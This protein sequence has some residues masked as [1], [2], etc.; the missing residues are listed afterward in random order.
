MI[1]Y[2]PISRRMFLVG[3][4]YV[5]SIPL[6]T[7]L[8]PRELQATETAPPLRFIGMA[9]PYSPSEKMFYGQLAHEVSGTTQV[10][11][12][13]LVNSVKYKSLS[14]ISGDISYILQP[15]TNLK[16]KISIV[17]GLDMVS[18]P[19]GAHPANFAM[20]AAGGAD[21]GK[22]ESNGY[23]PSVDQMIAGS[24]K[25]YPSTWSSLRRHLNLSPAY[26]SAST[27]N[28][29]M[30]LNPSWQPG[31]D[32][33][34]RVKHANKIT[35]TQSLMQRFIGSFDDGGSGSN[36]QL[37]PGG[38]A[39]RDILSKVLPMYQKVASSTKIST[40]DKHRLEN[41]MALISEIEKDYQAEVALTQC[42]K[43]VLETEGT[44]PEAP[45]VPG[46][47]SG[48]ID[49]AYLKRVEEALKAE[50]EWRIAAREV[51]DIRYRNH[52]KI[53]VAAMA[54]DLT[55][56]AYLSLSYD[57]QWAVSHSWH[58]D[59][60]IIGADETRDIFSATFLGQQRRS[61]AK[62]ATLMNMMDAVSEGSGTLLDNSIVYWAQ[63][64]GCIYIRGGAHS[65]KNMPVVVGGGG[66]GKLNTGYFIDYRQKTW[67]GGYQDTEKYYSG[68]PLNNLLVTFMNSFGMNS[69]DY[70]YKQG[71]GYGNYDRKPSELASSMFTTDARRSP[72]PFFFKG[73]SLG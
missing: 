39:R 29:S 71:E 19:M 69:T 28:K 62:M 6:L 64:F 51:E 53:L 37:A 52:M 55:R 45:T 67:Y 33:N 22:D 17:R 48:E 40:V 5:L 2:D 56:S 26:R 24:S 34:H 30:I 31:D 72:L 16:N 73:S 13:A 59:S 58:H 57:G 23:M 49:T 8:L 18:D 38:I 27:D 35:D 11:G 65:L 1:K 25:V 4:G 14:S 66:A 20:C 9:S 54:C 21:G 46:K 43:P 50:N 3:G 68:V 44:Y 32:E 60:G 7:S 63:Q 70:E 12:N 47:Q 41:Y 15:F 10:A 36:E 42:T 61:A